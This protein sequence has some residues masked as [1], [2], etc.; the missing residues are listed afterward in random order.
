MWWYVLFF[1]PIVCLFLF[2]RLFP[3]RNVSGDDN[4]LQ[5]FF[6]PPSW[7]FMVVWSYNALALGAL[8]ATC[9][10]TSIEIEN[11]SRFFIT[12]CLGI[13]LISL[14]CSWLVAQ[15]PEQSPHLTLALIWASILV[16]VVLLMQTTANWVSAL[17]LPTVLWL[18]VA[19]SLNAIYSQN[20]KNKNRCTVL[21]L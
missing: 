13:L 7:V 1:L 15:P 6:Q 12:L 14:W 4:Q 2:G 20:K 18:V 21:K 8:L 10:Q 19:S 16:L 17:L 11:K 9:Y 3:V 5:P